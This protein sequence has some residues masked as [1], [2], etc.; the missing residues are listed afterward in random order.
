MQGKFDFIDEEMDRRRQCHQVRELQAVE[1]AE[2]SWVRVGGRAMVNFCSND[3]LGLAGHPA[4]KQRAADYIKR[5]GAGSGASRL[6]CGNHV[7]FAPVEERLAAL[8]GAE[9]AMVFNSGFQANVSILAA[10][11]DRE[12]LILSDRLNH[13]SLIQGARLARCRIEIF[14]HNDLDHLQALL[15]K[16]S[17]RG[18]SRIFIVTESIFSM[19]GDQCPIDDMVSLARR[20]GAILVVDEAHATGVIGLRGMGLTCGKGVDVVIGTFSKGCG[21]FGAYVACSRKVR[22]YL[23]NCCA[24]IIYSTALPPAVLGAISGALA[25][26]PEMDAER[27]RLHGQADF[28]R[29]SLHRLGWDCGRSTTQIV[30]VIVG[31]ESDTLALSEWLKKN[32]IFASAIRPPTVEE[33]KSRIRLTVTLLHCE[34]DMQRVVDAFEQW[35]GYSA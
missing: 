24:G 4:L 16:S 20:F 14:D 21:A 27:H 8:K 12:S 35:K 6:V 13:N 25:L 33:N 29:N 3:Y 1:N 7:F 17:G 34:A 22:D 30:P 28:L 9:A 2:G 15:E 5:Y 18:F 19:D 10:L 31:K 11:A 26:I 32:D 23:I